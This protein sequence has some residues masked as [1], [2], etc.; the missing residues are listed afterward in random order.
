MVED[1]VEDV[2]ADVVPVDV[3][4][5]VAAGPAEVKDTV[6]M[7]AQ[8]QKKMCLAHLTDRVNHPIFP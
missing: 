8:A 1:V 7:S 5:V 3:D 2:G 4:E 6:L